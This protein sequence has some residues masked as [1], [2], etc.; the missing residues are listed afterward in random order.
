LGAGGNYSLSVR[1]NGMADGI[2]AFFVEFALS[3]APALGCLASPDWPGSLSCTTDDPVGLVRLAG[4]CECNVTGVFEISV[5]AWP[6]QD[7]APP[8]LTYGR[9]ETIGAAHRATAYTVAG[10]FGVGPLPLPDVPAAPLVDL[11]TA[12]RLAGPES[13]AACMVLTERLRVIAGAMLYATDGEL[14]LMLRLTD[15]RGAPDLTRAVLSLYLAPTDAPEWGGIA[16][17]WQAPPSGALYL[18]AP[19]YNSDGWYGLQYRGPVPNQSLALSLYHATLGPDLSPQPLRE[20]VYGSVPP[21]PTAFGASP[22]G[23]PYALLQLGTPPP[24]CPWDAR[25]PAAL[26]LTFT[27]QLPARTGQPP[28]PVLRKAAASLACNLSVPA[29]RVTISASPSGVLTIAVAVESFLRAYDVE[30]AMSDAQPVF[31]SGLRSLPASYAADPADPPSACP[32][33]YYFTPTGAFRRVPAHASPG[34]GCYGFSCAPGYMPDPT[35]PVCVPQYVADWI[36]WTV[37]S[38]VSTMAFAVIL[39][40]CTLRILCARKPEPEPLPEPEPEPLPDLTLPVSVTEQGDLLF[41]AV[42]SSESGSESADGE[43]YAEIESDG[44]H[45]GPAFAEDVPAS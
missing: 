30:L 9:V 13:L 28:P 26:V 1:L 38:L 40:A 29:R 31:A 17:V 22:D 44:E 18:P 42:I 43:A 36:F 27:A 16:A 20:R 41:E 21:A 10:R 25:F 12:W 2:A 14:T 5:L 37:V 8:T 33:G 39:C 24:P 35:A 15:R 32:R 6:A 34:P 4:T 19:L 7:T 11:S 45:E 23:A 3:P